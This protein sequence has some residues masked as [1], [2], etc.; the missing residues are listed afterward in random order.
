[1]TRL[2]VKDWA[3][4]LALVVLVALL[5]M[6][7]GNGWAWGLTAF[8]LVLPPL[9]FC[10]NFLVR[11]Q[12]GA[13]LTLP[14]TSPKSSACM[15]SLTLTNKSWLP[16]AKVLC[17]V[18]MVN[19]L[20]GEEQF[21]WLDGSI[22]PHGRFRRDFLLE[23]SHCGRIYVELDKAKLLDFFGLLPMPLSL[24]T[25][26]RLTVLP[27]LF[28]CQVSLSPTPALAED[29]SVSRKGDD[30]TEV[31]QLRE[32]QQGD[33]VR[34]IHWKLSSKLGGLILRESSQTED[35][36]LLVYWDKRFPCAPEQMDALAEITASVCQG[37]CDG[38]VSFDLGWTEGEE[39][40][41][42]TI[43]GEDQLLQTIPALVTQAGKETCPEL[44]SHAYGQVLYITSQLPQTAENGTV[45]CLICTPQPLSAGNAVTCT[46]ENYRETLERLAI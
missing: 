14:T 6:A 20:T 13:S 44:D 23:S 4:Y 10:G 40:E 27:D 15:A 41:M 29:S 24:K 9:S 25:G 28:S 34:R 17:R 8:V 3:Q 42:R 39:S 11:T 35:R 45:H 33:D 19:D 30:P 18:R 38:G 46:P 32:Y 36:S 22:P 1:M 43:S 2:C 26:A 5:A 16:A 12:L 37:L 7:T 31:F 21:L